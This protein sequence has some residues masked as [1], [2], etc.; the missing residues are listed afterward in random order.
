[1]KDQAAG[2]DTGPYPVE[3]V[4]WED[5][6]E[7]CRQLSSFPEEVAAGRTYRLPTEAQWEYACR[8]GTKTAFA[9]DLNEMAWYGYYSGSK[10][11]PVGTKKANGWGLY[12]MH[13]NAWEWCRDRYG[14]YPNGSATDPTGVTTGSNRVNRGGSW[15]S[16]AANCRSALR[17]WN[18]P[19]DRDNDLG[20]RPAAVP[21][22]R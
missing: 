1:M 7:F 16:P 12:D 17:N 19:D 8:A 5:A 4:T 10:T 3:R 18:A 14:E 21:L 9:G 6:T 2:L 13:G 15:F 11:N 22:G 20:F